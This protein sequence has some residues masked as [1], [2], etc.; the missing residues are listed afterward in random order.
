MDSRDEIKITGVIR[1]RLGIT[2]QA[3]TVDDLLQVFTDHEMADQLVRLD[4]FVF[5]RQADAGDIFSSFNSET[6]VLAT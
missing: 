1:T 2:A 6:R 5:G 3:E 4:L